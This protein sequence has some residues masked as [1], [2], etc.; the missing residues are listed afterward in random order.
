MKRGVRATLQLLARPFIE[1]WRHKGLEL[2]PFA[3][4]TIALLLLRA[5]L[6]DGLHT[7]IESVQ[8][9]FNLSLQVQERLQ[10]FAW[11]ILTAISVAAIL[12]CVIAPIALGRS[13]E[14]L[15][16]VRSLPKLM[17]A[18]VQALL[19]ATLKLRL[20][21]VLILACTA[22]TLSATWLESPYIQIA[23]VL[24][25]IVSTYFLLNLMAAPIFAAASSNK[26]NFQETLAASNFS[27]R[28]QILVVILATAAL[29]IVM[30]QLLVSSPKWL[31]DTLAISIGWYGLAL[32][33]SVIFPDPNAVHQ[34]RNTRATEN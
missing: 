8:H 5:L 1:L 14:A 7:Y 26:F 15:S 33:G 16:F 9:Q 19:L 31:A 18:S 2:I 20:Y 17:G 32:L 34:I 3:V 25:S 6:L 23:A 24:I 12:P 28:I 4:L 10:T 30:R 27:R 11:A 13:F 22:I 29:T 21:F